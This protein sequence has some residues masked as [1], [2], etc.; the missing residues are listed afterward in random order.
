MSFL[1]TIQPKL[2][3]HYFMPE[4]NK[5]VNFLNYKITK[6]LISLANQNTLIILTFGRIMFIITFEIN[7]NQMN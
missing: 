2:F 1:S 6:P 7:E 3:S 4:T 5:T